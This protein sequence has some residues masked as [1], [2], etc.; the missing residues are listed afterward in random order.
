MIAN[1]LSPKPSGYQS[2]ECDAGVPISGRTSATGTYQILQLTPSGS[3]ITE[4]VIPASGVQYE[5][6][7]GVPVGTGVVGLK[8]AGIAL[9]YE[10]VIVTAITSGVYELMPFVS[11][12][13]QTGGSVSCLLIKIG[14]LLDTY[15]NTLAFGTDPFA[16]SITDFAGG[17][18]GAWWHN[19]AISQIGTGTAFATGNNQTMVRKT[20]LDAGSYKLAV[21]VDTAITTT[22]TGQINVG[23]QYLNQI[24]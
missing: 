3:M 5:I 4:S 11:I 18:L 20:Y 13:A 12:D 22:G 23:L 9:A 14:S 8:A 16:G 6:E 10:N 17:G 19:L 15:A 24:G 1:A 7:T 2:N 21:I